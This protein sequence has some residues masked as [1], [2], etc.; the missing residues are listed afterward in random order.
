MMENKMKKHVRRCTICVLPDTFPGLKFNAEGVCNHCQNFKGE[1]NLREKKDRY[2]AKFDALV[3]KYKGRRKYDALLSYS[4]GKDSTYTLSL[5]KERYGLNVLAVTFDNGFLP[6]QTISNIEN[7]TAR[8][9]VDHLFIKPSFRMLKKIFSTCAKKNIY[10]PIALTR[11][12]TI[13]AACMAIVKFGSLRAA[14]E[15]NIPFIIF[16][17][18]PGQIP[19]SSSILKN[20]PQIVKMMQKSLYEPLYDLVGDAIDPYFLKKVHFE[21]KYSFPYNISPLVFLDYNEKEIVKQVKDLDW[22]RPEGIDANTTNCLLNSYANAIHKERYGYHP[23]AFEMAKLVREGYLDRSKALAK[24]E[25]PE[26]PETIL[27]VEK[28]L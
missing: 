23:Y 28:R 16:G 10:P 19:L 2:R 6:E 20:N 4:G 15:K 1:K 27:W 18:S 25:Q 5:V 22:R 7:V 3:E 26:D 12:S 14:L 13:C 9:R 21:E 17:W 8:L 24:L 11:A